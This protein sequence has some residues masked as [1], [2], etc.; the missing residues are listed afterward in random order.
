MNTTIIAESLGSAE[1]KKN[2]GLRYAYV[3]GAMYK[4]IASKELVVAMGKAG[5]MGYLGT[6]GMDPSEID[7]SIQFVQRELAKGEAY[8]ANLICNLEQPQVEERTVELL[9]KRDVRHVEAAAFISMTPSL[10]FWRLKGLKRA[11]DGGIL[12]SEESWRRCRAL[13][14]RRHSCSRPQRR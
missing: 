3:A 5:M 12:G 13:K 2:Y 6:G 1:F 8:G 11:A 7:A 14:L 4:G 9:L 10:V